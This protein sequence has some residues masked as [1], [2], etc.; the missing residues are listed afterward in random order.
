[1]LYLR[2]VLRILFGVLIFNSFN[3]FAEEI[4]TLS[5][6]LD[7]GML[8]DR[9]NKIFQREELQRTL[10]HEKKKHKHGIENLE[11]KK[12]EEVT[13]SDISFLLKAFEISKSEILTEEEIAKI[14][15]PYIEKEVTTAE[16]YSL[17]LIHI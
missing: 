17:S 9:N 11:E 1:M 6:E 14:C 13:V 3:I 10:K 12:E 15:K 4:G 5:A 2:K 16:L 8:L 7:T